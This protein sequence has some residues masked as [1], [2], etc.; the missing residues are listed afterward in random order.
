MPGIELLM[1]LVEGLSGVW[2][3][4]MIKFQQK[5]NFKKTDAFFKKIGQGDYL[6]GLKDFGEAGVKALQDA[7][8]K[9]TGKTSESWSYSIKKD[10]KGVSLIWN[11]SNINDGVCVA[12][13][14]QYGHLMPSGYYVEGIDYINPA[15]KPLFDLIGKR[16]WE[17]VTRDA[18]Y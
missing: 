8:P 18:Q 14:I 3:D 9:D 10:K 5:G 16:V 7:T 1:M 6:K 13:V 17:E 12:V 11:N 15:L 4:L 2:G